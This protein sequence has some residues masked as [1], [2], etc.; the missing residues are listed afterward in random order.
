MRFAFYTN[1]FS[2]HQLPL[3]KALMDI[4][5]KDDYRYISAHPVS[6]ERKQIGWGND[7]DAEWYVKEWE[8]RD[9]ARKILETADVVMSGIRDIPLMAYRCKCGL[10][11]IY[12]SER[13][14]KPCIGMLRMLRPSYFMM[15]WRFAKLLRNSNA[16]CYFP[17]GI[18]AARDMAR[19]SG[20]FNGDVRCIFKVPELEFDRKPGGGIWLEGGGNS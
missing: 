10:R 13:W 8:D 15:A 6:D 4:L 3:A 20:L 14:F 1:S 12:C 11:T 5:G 16:I 2:P 19:L 18:H 9:T 7:V 17:I